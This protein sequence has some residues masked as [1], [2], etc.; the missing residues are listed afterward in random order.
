MSK[1]GFMWE[2]ECGNVEY[3]QYPPQECEECQAIESFAKVPEDMIEK[4]E[5]E[6]VLAMQP[7]EE[8]E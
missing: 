1:D 5:A 4:K 8:D 6:N 2:C 3:G 7:E